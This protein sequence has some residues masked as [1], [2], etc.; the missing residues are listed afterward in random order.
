MPKALTLSIVIPV[1]NEENYLEAC[2]TAISQQTV[3]PDKVI[4]VDNG[5]TDSTVEIAQQF[6]FVTLLHEQKP[7]VLYARTT[8]YNAVTTDL[9]A[10]IDAD[11][12]LS[13]GW[14]R[15]AKRLFEDPRVY[16]VTG[17]SAIYDMPFPRLTRWF[18]DL[19]LKVAVWGGFHFLTGCNM[20]M[21]RSSWQEVKDQLC[22]DL[23]LY[24]DI[25]LAL[26]L[27]L[28]NKP[29]TY[30]SLLWSSVSSRRFSD[31][32]PDFIHYI[33]RYSQ[34]FRKHHVM[35]IGVYYAEFAYL[36]TYILSKPLFW[37]YDP[38][39]R[40]LSLKYLFATKPRRIDPMEGRTKTKT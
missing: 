15:R 19:L 25:D 9:I 17:P 1:Y 12:H 36:V 5:S 23:T 33:R 18:H 26:H 28:Q 39:R 24:E 34:T 4:V 10:R 14:V 37:F 21:R 31:T 22:D 32:L 38:A 35:N 2:L 20:A 3:P 11:T 7:S 16:A 6:P 29:P 8:G 30:S 40:R 13:R 27:S